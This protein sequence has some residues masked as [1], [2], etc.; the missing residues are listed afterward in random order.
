[1]TVITKDLIR[2]HGLSD[3]EYA[4][5][6]GLLGRDFFKFVF[7]KRPAIF[8]GEHF[9]QPAFTCQPL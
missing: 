1:M 6:K 9:E 4:R 5:I 2:E 3:E 7:S 8:L